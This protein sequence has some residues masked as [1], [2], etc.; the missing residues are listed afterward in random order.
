MLHNIEIPDEE[1]EQDDESLIESWTPRLVD[2][3]S[4][5]ITLDPAVTALARWLTARSVTLFPR[6]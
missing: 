4:I 5:K 1:E 3:A 2:S 6:W